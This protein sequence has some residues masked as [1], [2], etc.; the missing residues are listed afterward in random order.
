MGPPG[1]CSREVGMKWRV[2]LELVGPDGVHEVGGCATSAEYA[3]RLL[4]LL[5]HIVQAK[6]PNRDQTYYA[7]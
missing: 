4:A 2:V 1:H 5:V 6:L 7:K 3:P